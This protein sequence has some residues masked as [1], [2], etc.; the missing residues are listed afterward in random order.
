M[1]FFYTTLQRIKIF[2]KLRGKR[3]LPISAFITTNSSASC[4]AKVRCWMS[5]WDVFQQLGPGRSVP[6]PADAPSGHAGMEPGSAPPPGRPRP[7]PG[8]CVTVTPSGFGE[9][10]P[11]PRKERR[12]WGSLIRT[13]L[14][15][16]V[17]LSSCT[18]LSSSGDTGVIDLT[19][20][21]FMFKCTP[22]SES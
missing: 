15:F 18:A 12:L 22:A 14:H 19:D 6:L 1:L 17:S 16:T 20:L 13:K 2:L 5:G 7:R 10:L 11:C 3:T 21:K 8:R 4:K 9:I